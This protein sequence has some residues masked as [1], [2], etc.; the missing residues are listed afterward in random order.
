L[1][2]SLCG[3]MLRIIASHLLAPPPPRRAANSKPPSTAGIHCAGGAVAGIA[4]G[5]LAGA[6]AGWALARQRQQQGT[7]A[8][9]TPPAGDDPNAVTTVSE[10]RDVLPVRGSNGSGIEDAPK[11]LMQ[12]DE[13]MTRYIEQSPFLQLGTSDSSGL[14]YVSPKGDHN[15]FVMVLDSKTLIIPD[16]P[17]NNILMGLQNLLD[18]PRCGI[19]FEIPGNATTLRVGG[20]TSLRKDPELLRRLAARGID[21]TLAI[22][23]EVDYAF[24]HC[25]KAYMRSRLWEPQSWPAEPM[26]VSL[27][28]YFAENEAE[29]AEIDERVAETYRMVQDSVEGKAPEA[30]PPTT[31]VKK[32][33][34]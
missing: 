26:E 22:K 23:V 16:R 14:P 13:Q 17:G 10:L 27:G 33:G 21:A 34:E 20:R 30:Y 1:K 7:P 9:T 12:L 25:A 11:V 24:F 6:A 5:A 18:N 31:T 29:A 3:A 2:L 15:G 8:T 28:M 4:V 19:C 32:D